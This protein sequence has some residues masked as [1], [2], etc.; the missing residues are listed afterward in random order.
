[1]FEKENKL[2]KYVQVLCFKTLSALMSFV[3]T[4]SCY[5]M[6]CSHLQGL[7]GKLTS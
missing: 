4:K 5:V 6:K 1:M 3:Y 7:S 2:T